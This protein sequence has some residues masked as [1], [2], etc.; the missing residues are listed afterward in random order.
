M[1]A[2]WC[3]DPTEPTGWRREDDYATDRARPPVGDACGYCGVILSAPPAQ[4]YSKTALGGHH[5]ASWQHIIPAR[6]GGRATM[7][8]SR[9]AC[10]R[11]NQMLAWADDCPAALAATLAIAGKH[12]RHS[13]TIHHFR[14]LLHQ[15][16]T[17]KN[18][19]R[20]T[21]AATNTRARAFA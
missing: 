2:L 5:D 20:V 19:R 13:L 12:R 14:A 16:L 15:P 4:G 18:I 1:P 11:C 17:P 6:R 8:N 7:E 3:Y 10:R 21:A 9:P